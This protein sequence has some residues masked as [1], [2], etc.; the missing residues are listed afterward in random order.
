MAYVST[1]K[2]WGWIS[3]ICTILATISWCY[4]DFS[5]MMSALHKKAG[6]ESAVAIIVV[7]SC[8]MSESPVVEVQH[9]NAIIKAISEDDWNVIGKCRTKWAILGALNFHLHESEVCTVQTLGYP[10]LLIDGTIFAVGT[11]SYNAISEEISY[12]NASH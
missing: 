6:L 8:N 5:R 11:D 1:I 9:S 3:C 7:N 10:C 4:I 12:V 2:H